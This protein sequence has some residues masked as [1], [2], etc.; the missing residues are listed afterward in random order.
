MKRIRQP[1]EHENFVFFQVVGLFFCHNGMADAGILRSVSA[2]FAVS[3]SSLVNIFCNSKKLN[4]KYEKYE[5]GARRL[6][7]SI[8]L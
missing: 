5:G 4:K 1:H 2:I 7:E 6:A 3:A 8:V